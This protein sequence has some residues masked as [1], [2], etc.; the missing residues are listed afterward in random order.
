VIYFFYKNPLI[1]KLDERLFESGLPFG[2]LKAKSAK[3]A[4][5]EAV[6]QI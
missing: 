2:F 6:C 5:F 1:K 3:L 4:V